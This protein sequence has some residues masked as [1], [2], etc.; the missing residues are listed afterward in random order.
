[1]RQ[2]PAALLGRGAF[3]RPG[4]GGVDDDGAITHVEAEPGATDQ[5]GPISDPHP[6]ERERFG[7]LLGA[8]WLCVALV[9]WS[10]AAERRVFHLFP[11]EPAQ[12]A[13][14]RWLS[15]GTD[16]TLLDHSTWQPGLAIL[17]AP[18]YWVTDDAVVVFRAAIALNAA[19]GGLCAVLLAMLARRLTALSLRSCVFAAG[20][21]ALL[22]A[23]LSSSAHVWA[24]PLVTL[25][26]LGVLLVIMRYL[27]TPGVSSGLIVVAAAGATFLVHGR[28]LPLLVMSAVVLVANELRR[29][30]W[31]RAV[32]FAAASL[33]AYLV[34]KWFS[35]VVHRAVWDGAND[36]NTV[37][38]TLRRLSSPT[39]VAQTFVGQLWYQL[40]TTAALA[41]IGF[42][43]LTRRVV[44]RDPVERTRR[45]DSAVV[46]GLVV[47]LV[48]VSAVFMSGRPETHHLIYGRYNDAV[49]W[50]VLVVAIGWLSSRVA[51]APRSELAG[52]LVPA[53]GATLV[54]A[55]LVQWWHGAA[56][57]E[58]IGVRAMVPG[59]VAFVGD[60]SSID[61]V[62]PTLFG[63]VLLA[64]LVL[65]GRSR[66]RL[67]PT[68]TAL[69]VVVT[70]ALGFL[71]VHE[72]LTISVNSFASSEQ[73]RAVADIVPPGEVIGYHLVGV[74]E[75]SM[76]LQI[77]QRRGAQLYQMYLPD[78]RFELD[79]GPDDDV[80]PY[81]FA[82]RLDPDMIAA[83]AVDLWESDDIGMV[84]WLEP[85][86]P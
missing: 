17:L 18:I 79:H 4:S 56:L 59:L 77:G 45:R 76:V 65:L 26:F 70:L 11:D 42:I 16:W 83:G 8:L 35:D 2:S 24:E 72:G 13:M 19:I 36:V 75:P 81:V 5:T 62:V 41:G 6:R 86:A 22:P 85:T 44:G 39:D 50:P 29:A 82:P 25:T 47:P 28:L 53:A 37:T 12:L 43:V 71:R 9:R 68:L 80:G 1:M 30:T 64:Q 33:V 46:L 57:E 49:M 55:L 58:Y 27:D 7:W 15:G 31:P 67:A 73:V 3:A 38:S 40:A 32:L 66:H 14:G 63:L 20:A 52:V 54:S 84:L 60:R 10:F 78:H 23:G 69:V 34:T 51:A 21:V 48:G 74:D 61:A